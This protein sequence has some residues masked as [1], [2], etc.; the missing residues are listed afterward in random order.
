MAILE[1]EK[2]QERFEKIFFNSGVGIFIVDKNRDIMECNETFCRIFGYEY[3]EIIGKSARVIHVS[4]KKYLRFAEIGFNKVRKNQALYLNYEFRHK[5]GKPVWL[6]ISGDSI[7]AKK[8]VL[9]IIVDITEQVLMEK[10]LKE[11]KLK[12]KRLNKTLNC[13]VENQLKLIRQKDEQLQYQSRLVQMGEILNMIAHQWRQP[14]SAISATT[15][16]LSTSLILNNFSKESFLD[17]IN[18]IEKY[19][20]HLS[21]TIDDFR[22]F[23][24][25]TKTKEVTSLEEITNTTIDIV[26]AILQAQNIKI[27]LRYDCNVSFLTYKNELSQ[28]ILNIVKNAQDAFLERKID[29]RIIEISTY[30]E[31]EFLCLSIKDNA[32]GIKE[33]IIDKIF[34]IYFS[35][36]NSK[37]GTGLGLYMSRIIIEDH[38][39]GK[40]SVRNL[41]DGCIFTI[42]LPK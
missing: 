30:A 7:S 27:Y 18:K 26:K 22:N 14:L 31:N 34:D 4:E 16:F 40:L 13:E 35:T 29:N 41:E 39:N 12:I 2:N 23:F 20:K 6:R 38:C 11:S 36:K 1:L 8:E 32:G 5:N 24:K 37:N 10:K 9:W 17:E 19:A 15:S 33:E 21:D 42:K 28:A 25:Q 3:D